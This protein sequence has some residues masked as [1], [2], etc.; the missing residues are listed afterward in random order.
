MKKKIL[1]LNPNTSG[2]A[3]KR[4]EEECRKVASPETEVKATC[5]PSKPEFSSW[6]VLSYVDFTI[7]AAEATKIAWKERNNYDGLIVAGFSD[8]GLDAIKEL[9]N[10]PVI[11]I[12]ETA[13][14]IASLLGHRFSVLTGT[15]KWTPPKH[16]Y[17]K[18]VGVESKVVSFRSYSEWEEIAPPEILREHLITTAKK[19]IKEDGAEVI[20]LG[21]GPLV[22]Y[23]RKIE[24]ELGVPVVDP[25][26]TALKVMEGLIDLGL[27]H[28][29]IGRWKNPKEK[30]G[31]IAYNRKWLDMP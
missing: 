26:V 6:I 7:C 15:S 17:V 28:S 5:I 21:G 10:I 4:M 3:T 29:K 23:G 1:I 27:K 9:L 14:H 24:K 18:A 20:I 8:V 31:N 19:A 22:G 25:T 12:A 13:Y 11:G 30:I 2:E 16:D